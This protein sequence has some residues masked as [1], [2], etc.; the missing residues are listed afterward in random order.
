MKLREWDKI[1]TNLKK[2]LL[3]LKIL[4]LSIKLLMNI[5]LSLEVKL[6]INEEKGG[7]IKSLILLFYSSVGDFKNIRAWEA[8][9][10]TFV[11]YF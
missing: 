11:N 7:M 10:R 3:N 6:S 1:L 5:I 8:E 4:F 9:Y 2:I